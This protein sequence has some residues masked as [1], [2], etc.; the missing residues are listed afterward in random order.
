[1]RKAIFISGCGTAYTS[2]DASRE[3]PELY[4]E[5]L[6]AL[7]F[8]NRRDFLL[9]LVTPEF[10]EYKWLVSALKD[11]TIA[12][13]HW[14]MGKIDLDYFADIYDINIEESYFITD[15]LYQKFFQE[16]GCKIVLVL[17]GRG[18]QTLN[19]KQSKDLSEYADISKNIYAAAFSV[20]LDK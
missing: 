20:A 14:D 13:F 15:G 2:I 17:T 5:T 8:L 9:V 12:I 4:P 18:V 11:K 19:S 10:Q 3:N 1:M 6:W 7:R 16:K